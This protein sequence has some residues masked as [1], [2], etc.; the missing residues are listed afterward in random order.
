MQSKK[1]KR[2]EIVIGQKRSARYVTELVKEIEDDFKARRKARKEIERQWE[3]NMNFL[4]GNQYCHVNRLGEI[5]AD[6]KDYFWQNRGVFNHIAPLMEIRLSKLSRINPAIYVRPK[7]DDDKDV[8][9]ANSAEKLINGTFNSL[10]VSDIVKKVT[11]WSE[12]CGTG[13]YKV[14]WN[15]YGGSQVGS[16]D[17]TPVYEGEVE[18]L[19]VS[20]FEIFPDSLFNEDV[21]DCNSII[22]ARAMTTSDVYEK[23]GVE[24]NGEEIGVYNLSGKSG[25]VEDLKNT[26]KDAVIVIEKYERPSEQFPNGRIMTVAGGELL[27]YGELPYVNGD[28]KSRIFPFVKQTSI[29]KTGS[30]F[31]LSVIERLI[32]IQRAYNAVKNRKHEFMN[33]LLM[34]VLTVED[35]AIDVDDLSS[36]GLSPGKI[37][38]YRQGAKPPELMTQ[39]TM[40]DDFNDEE[41]KLLNEFVVVSGVSDVTSSSTNASLSSGTALELLIEQDN[42]RLL[43]TAE[44]IRN[45]Y[46]ALARHTIRLHGQFFAGVRAVKYLDSYR[47]AKIYYA[48]KA[49]VNSDDVY[50]ANE[51][52]LMESPARKKETVLKLLSSGLLSD[53][54]GEVRAETKE[55]I[56]NILGYK[57]LDYHKGLSKLHEEKALR[58][59]ENMRKKEVEIE[60]IDDDKIH[61]DEHTR[62]MLTEY[63]ELSK[64]VKDRFN[65]HIEAHRTRINEQ[66]EIKERKGE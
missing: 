7:T 14:L 4:V 36:E 57:D 32:P 11:A 50:L 5:D 12:T 8:A 45:C 38:V 23:Y 55:K 59:N 15:N 22:H 25:N 52:E 64:E 61:I 19:A 42:E 1:R 51:N 40:P 10:H 41:K 6:G 13:F 39:T 17:D 29:D 20:P 58:E 26:L 35:G 30:F 33:R 16:L 27:Y 56:L 47:R 44:N 60:Q 21:E 65:A 24:L 3:L 66:K 48:D 28:D 37:L 9:G 2:P 53:D 31:G 49:A 18:I 62:Y 34:G 46:L 43:A 63:E 54:N